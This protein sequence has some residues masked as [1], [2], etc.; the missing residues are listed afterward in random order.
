MSI[1]Y[2]L[3]AL[4]GLGFLIFIH[5]LGHYIVAR[6]AGMTVEVFS[7]GF[8]P[9]IRQWQIHGVKW[10]LCMLPFGGYVRIAGMEKKAGL[11]PHQI[12]DG[13]YGK[14][15]IQRI[16]VA[17]AGPIANIIFAFVAFCIIWAT[18][19][20]NKPFQ[21]YTRVIGYVDP[22]S[23]FY[24]N[25][26][27]AGDELDNIDGKKIQ[28]FQDLVISL[29]LDEKAAATVKGNEIDYFAGKKEPFSVALAAS[30]PNAPAVSQLGIIPA[31]YLIFDSYSSAASPLQ[32]S[33]I[34]KGDRLVW[35]DGELIFSSQQLSTILNDSITLLTVERSGRTFL[36]QVPRLKISDLCLNAEQKN[37]L[38]DWQ[39]EAG[40]KSKVQQLFFIP[41]LLNHNGSIEK[42][43]SFMNCNADKVQPVV[44]V[45]HPFATVLQPGD[46]II[47]VDGTPVHNGIDLLHRLQSRQALVIVQR[48][49]EAPVASWEG[50]DAQFE[51]SFKP[52]SLQAIISTI[53]SAS[54]KNQSDSFILLPPVE[55]KTL[56]ELD[57]D[58][59]T[60]TKMHAQYEAQKK[61]IEKIENE[62]ERQE[63]L[64]LLEQSQKRLIL[65]A[66]LRDQLVSYN[67]PPTTLFADVFDQTWKTLANLVT[68]YLS[69]KALAGPVGIV[70]A[71]Q[72]SWASGIKDALFWLGFVSLN[73]AILNLLPIPVLDGG[74]ILFASIEAITKK[75]IKAK[76]MEKFILPFL[77]LLVVLFIY[78]T[79][80]DIVRLLHRLF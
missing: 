60:K 61:Q 51:S 3:L 29:M 78:L 68:G 71:L 33:G 73:L 58:P 28:S 17:L 35:V 25:G 48:Q 45:R 59:E 67:P 8:G 66:K 79:Y 6:R 69:P 4:L 72:T 74:H 24:T 76:T 7:I 39:H 21:Q 19:G 23:K 31:Q 80:Q 5:E 20:Q 9:A 57:L 50:A 64:V 36:A 12:P 10:Q 44:E 16:K 70:Q 40:Y 41:Y 15:P 56:S 63:Q 26:V 75:P 1:F 53:G 2:L 11:E 65:G 62:Q 37:E 49:K 34:Q 38:D 43:L 55:L 27:R 46:R 13:F 32:N 14:K 22:Q 30:T 77:I 52:Q 18:G 54:P 42:S 47:A